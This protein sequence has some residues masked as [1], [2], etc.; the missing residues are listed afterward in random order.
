MWPARAIKQELRPSEMKCPLAVKENPTNAQRGEEAK[1][2]P[3][4]IGR[5]REIL[6]FPP[7]GIG[8]G[9]SSWQN[10]RDDWEV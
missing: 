3:G 8:V 6:S 4:G 7:K 9:R 5:Q 1:G 10:V 2:L